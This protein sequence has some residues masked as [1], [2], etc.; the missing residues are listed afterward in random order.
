MERRFGWDTHGIPVEYEIDKKLDIKSKDDVM[1]MGID[2][3]N[4]EC[5]AIVMRYST[6]W[7]QTIER[8]GR[9]IDFDNDYKVGNYHYG[10]NLLY[11]LLTHIRLCTRRIWSLS[12]GF[13]NSFL[14]KSKSTLA[15]VSCPTLL[16]APP[17]SQISK[18]SKTT[19]MSKILLSLSVS[20]FWKTLQPNFWPGRRRHGPSRHT[21]VLQSTRTSSTSRSTTRRRAGTI[22]FLNR[23]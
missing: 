9:W 22:S 10:N 20:L 16:R 4:A 7:R 5:R 12:G 1:K 21:L 6:E 19:K 11:L 18:P 15:T 23:A 8:L 3:Y 2:K 17:R 14:T 13:A